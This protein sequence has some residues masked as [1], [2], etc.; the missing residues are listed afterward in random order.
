LPPSPSPL[1]SYYAARASEYDRVYLKPERQADLRPFELWLPA[2]LAGATVLEIA[3]GTGYWTRFIAPVASAVVA[4]DA[5]PETLRIA[6]QHVRSTNTELR[7]GDAYALPRFA[8]SF[9]AAF[10]G[11]WFSHVPLERQREFLLGLNAALAPGA[12]VVLLDNLFVAG[13]S[14]ALGEQDANGNTYQRR[15]LSDGSV[16]RVLKNFPTEAQLHRLM[17]A[18]LGAS[19][20][21]RSWQY[22]WA[23]EYRVPDPSPSQAT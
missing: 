18:G 22:Y 10:A 3:C 11:F 14:S 4:L 5:S 15:S 19:A 2:V 21:Y 1:Q 12:R 6:R 7:I 13:S 9:D 16:H 8:R 23:F 20:R 17:A